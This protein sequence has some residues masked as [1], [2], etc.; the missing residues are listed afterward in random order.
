MRKLLF[1]AILFLN[2]ACTGGRQLEKVFPIYFLNSQ[3]A[4]VWVLNKTIGRDAPSVSPILAQRTTLTF[5][6]NGRVRKQAYIRLGSD[7]GYQGN[8]NIQA[9][10]H[11]KFL[12]HI[13]I[14]GQPETYKVKTITA[15]NMTLIN[16]HS[17]ST[18]I[19]NTLPSPK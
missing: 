14:S 16:A 4:K 8:Y 3:S 19:F 10:G 9:L 12:L 11:G 15:T 2:F 5:F 6:N 13:Y 17:D 18:L 7:Y 1:I